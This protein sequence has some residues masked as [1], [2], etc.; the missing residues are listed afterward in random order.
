LFDGPAN[1]I[2]TGDGRNGLGVGSSGHK[3]VKAVAAF[4]KTNPLHTQRRRTGT[5]TTLGGGMVKNG[6]SEK[7]GG[8]EAEREQEFACNI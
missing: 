5:G 2:G 1:V 4:E 6:S 8:G 3:K 7:K